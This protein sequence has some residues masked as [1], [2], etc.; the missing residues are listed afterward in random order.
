MANISSPNRANAAT[1][2]ML[3]GATSAT[4]SSGVTDNLRQYVIFELV[5]VSHGDA[6]IPQGSM[7]FPYMVMH[8]NP[9]TWEESY[10]K[11]I[12]RTMTR[13]GF[14]EQHWGEELDTISCSGSTGA[15]VSVRSGLSMLNRK[16]SIA[17]RK[18]LELVALYRN[19]GS[20]YDQRGNIVFHGGINLHFDSNIYTGYF[21]NLTVNETADNGFTF[22]VDFSYKVEHSLRTMG[23]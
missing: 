7:I 14:V 18:Y 5:N 17:Y 9:E 19:N 11:L 4:A 1:T 20:V 8:I 22:K 12:N 10:T 23:R 15:F 13:G 2:T 6:S 21:E 16:A 3:G